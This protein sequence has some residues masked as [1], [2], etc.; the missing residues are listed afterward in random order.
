[1]DFE[2][3]L[4]PLAT[5]ALVQSPSTLLPLPN[6]N[7]ANTEPTELI[8]TASRYRPLMTVM[9]T[10]PSMTTKHMPTMTR[11][12]LALVIGSV[13]HFFL[14]LEIRLNHPD[15]EKCCDAE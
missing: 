9:A 12:I 7:H 1:M 5:G 11:Q 6:A 2:L 8:A 14:N 3:V 13:P 10:R 4:S 15:N